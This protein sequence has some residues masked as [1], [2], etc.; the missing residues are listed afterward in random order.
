MRVKNVEGSVPPEVLERWREEWEISGPDKVAAAVLSRGADPLVYDASFGP[1][2]KLEA[3]K[4]WLEEKVEER[5]RR[6]RRA[7]ADR[8]MARWHSWINTVVAVLALLAALFLDQ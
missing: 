4:R 8:R 1:T 2:A 7:E 5:S 6:L 3:T